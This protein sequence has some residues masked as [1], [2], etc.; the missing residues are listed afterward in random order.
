[1]KRYPIL[2]ACLSSICSATLSGTVQLPSGAGLSGVSVTLRKAGGS[3]T[4]GASGTWTIATTSIASHAGLDRTLTTNLSLRD[5]RLVLDLQGAAPNGVRLSDALRTRLP[6]RAAGRMAAAAID[7]LVFSLGGTTRATLAVGTLD[8]T[9]ILTVID[10]AAVVVDQ[11]TTTTTWATGCTTTKTTCTAGTWTAPGPSPDRS[12]YKLVKESDHFAIYSDETVADADATSALSTL[13]NTVW[14]NLF[15]S[16][17]FMPEPFCNTATKYKAA[18]HVHSTD[19]LTGGGWGGT[20]S[21]RIGMWV[22]PGALADHWGLTHEF[23]HSWQYSQTY[24][25]GL[26][27]P[28]SNTCGWVAETHANWTP[29]Q[30]PE[31]QS[32]VHCSEMLDNMPHLN[33]GD[34]RD[35]YC[36]WQFFEY[37]KD[38]YC[39]AAVNAVWTTSGVDPLTNIQKS[40]A[41]TVSQLND[42]F[43]DWAMHNVTWDYKATPGAFRT[44]YGDITKTDKAERMRRLMPLEALD[45]SWATDRRFVSPFY[46]APQR[47]GYNVVRLYPESGAST[48]TVTFR[49]INQTGSNADFRWGL[50]ATNSTFTTPRYSA[51]KSGLDGQIVF[52]VNAGEPLFLVVVGTPTKFETVTFEQD[53]NTTWRFPYMIQLANAWPQ[54]FQNGA[55]DACPSGTVRH[56]N[57][58]GC[59]PSSTPSTVYVGPYARILSGGSASGTARI[60]DEAIVV[61][62]SVSG[63]IVGGL[64]IIGETGSQYGNNAFNVSGSAQIR[65]TFY[66]LGFFEASQAASGT[67]NIYG[68]VEFRGTGT[69]VSS[70]NHSGFVDGTQ[71]SQNTTDKNSKG[72]WTWRP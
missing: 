4:T 55:L 21:Y 36:D 5:G 10:T 54:G 39:P 6:L 33:L 12:G 65:T 72:P 29:H 56:A 63:G 69:N 47:F 42:F 60:E 57:G 7:T 43:G 38:K 20:G 9:G 37:L 24:S 11:G 15:N 13:E 68:D 66:P 27:C 67:A 61:N 18:I 16:N 51:M 40:Q 70:G 52:K 71:S 19:G 23:T 41:W 46:G 28:N 58:G 3:A 14:Q 8:S 50:V 22:G 34:A 53:Y 64:S 62:G 35:R 32:N 31:Y 26:G 25:G 49:G 1:M 45:S 59:A 30:L 44:T 17:I 2:L 48:V